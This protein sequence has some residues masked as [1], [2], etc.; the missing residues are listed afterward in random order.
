MKNPL[1]SQQKSYLFNLQSWLQTLNQF[2]D[3]LK[4]TQLICNLVSC[5]ADYELNG[6]QKFVVFSLARQDVLYL[7]NSQ[8]V[9]VDQS[10]N[11]SFF[12][13]MI[14]VVLIIKRK[15]HSHSKGDVVDLQ[16]VQQDNAVIDQHRL[17][18]SGMCKTFKSL[19]DSGF[20]AGSVKQISLFHYL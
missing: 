16:G 20:R 6:A 17:G 4:Y 2:S 10:T 3:V 7:A 14:I 5:N 1:I 11:S 19:A 9:P 15:L 12:I 13:S 18:N 8:T